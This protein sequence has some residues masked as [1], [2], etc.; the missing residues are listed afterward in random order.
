MPNTTRFSLSEI[1]A[2]LDAAAFE[3]PTFRAYE[4]AER[5]SRTH[6]REIVT[7]G[8]RQPRTATA[9]IPTFNWLDSA[10]EHYTSQCMP[11]PQAVVEAYALESEEPAQPQVV[12]PNKDKI[13]KQIQDCESLS[14]NEKHCAIRG[15]ERETTRKGNDLSSNLRS[16]M[17]WNSTPEGYDFWNIISD[18][19]GGCGYD[20]WSEDEDE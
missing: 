4:V 9:D 3:W 6:P 16:L 20:S 7:A 19:I 2:S 13:I 10:L 18:S 11:D 12:T 14:I 15:V 1:A 17:V 8:N 5:P